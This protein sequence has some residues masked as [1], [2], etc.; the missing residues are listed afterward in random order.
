MKKI[1]KKIEFYDIDWDTDHP[2]DKDY[3]PKKVTRKVSISFD[4]EMDGADL[5]ADEYGF[6]VNGFNFKESSE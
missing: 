5:L 4:P 2:K 6:C 1:T 3:L